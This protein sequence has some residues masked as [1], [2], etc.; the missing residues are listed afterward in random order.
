MK[1]F[2]VSQV[3]RLRIFCEILPYIERKNFV[4]SADYEAEKKGV[5]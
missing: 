3:L 1:L 4:N 2:T 5:I